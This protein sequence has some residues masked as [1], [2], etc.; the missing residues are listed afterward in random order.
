MFWLVDQ[1]GAVE[2]IGGDIAADGDIAGESECEEI[3]QEQLLYGLIL[4]SRDS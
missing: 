1:C 3:E 2:F 4:R